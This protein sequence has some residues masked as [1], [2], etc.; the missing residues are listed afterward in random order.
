MKRQEKGMTKKK[1]IQLAEKRGISIKKNNISKAKPLE[2]V[3]GNLKAERD[4]SFKE[5]FCR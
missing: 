3:C 1:L 2:K 5:L 4:M